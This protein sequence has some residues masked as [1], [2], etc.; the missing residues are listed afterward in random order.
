MRAFQLHNISIPVSLVTHLY[1][2]I[3]IKT[4]F[5]LVSLYFSDTNPNRRIWPPSVLLCTAPSIRV[6]HHAAGGVP[7]RTLTSAPAY[8]RW[9]PLTPGGA[10]LPRLCRQR[11][12]GWG[13]WS[14]WSGRGRA[15]TA[16]LLRPACKAP[17]PRRPP[18]SLRTRPTQLRTRLRSTCTS[19]RVAAQGQQ[20]GHPRLPMAHL[21]VII[22][23]R[24]LTADSTV[25]MWFTS[26]ESRPQ[27]FTTDLVG[28]LSEFSQEIRI[29]KGMYLMWCRW[30]EWRAQLGRRWQHCGRS[31]ACSCAAAPSSRQLRSR[32]GE[33]CMCSSGCSGGVWAR[34][35]P[36]VFRLHPIQSTLTKT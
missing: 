18:R 6:A 16:P 14:R 4:P 29:R 3:N 24:S 8:P 17:L 33:T 15:T 5:F 1:R 13:L 23:Y 11:A 25:S 7:W 12:A 10:H 36:A 34:D 35:G 28:K 20:Q 26:S 21:P 32:P 31:C 9:H 19:P 22:S 27:R 30:R 2:S